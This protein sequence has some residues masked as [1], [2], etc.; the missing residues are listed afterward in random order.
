M[1]AFLAVGRLGWLSVSAGHPAAL[2]PR[3]TVR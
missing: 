2:G 3:A 1:A